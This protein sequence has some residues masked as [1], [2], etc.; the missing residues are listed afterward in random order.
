M[1]MA[2]SRP[3]QLG[4][5][6]NPSVVTPATD[7]PVDHDA[8]R[9]AD[10]L[11]VR[12][13]LDP[14]LNGRYPADVVDDLEV[15][16][17]HLPIRDGDLETISE[18]FDWLGVNYYFSSRMSGMDSAG[19]TVD[20]DGVPVE[21]DVP[22]GRPLTAMGWEIVPDGLS[23]LL[24]R[25]SRDYP[26]TPMVITESGAAFDDVPDETGF[27]Q[28]DERVAYLASHIAAVARAREA[29]A[30]VHGYFV[31]TFLDNF[32]WSY[33]YDKRF[34]LVR[35]DYDTQRRTPKHSAHWYRDTIRRVRGT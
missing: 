31:W 10:G 16:G 26:G 8:A 11:G 2:A 35:V 18:P 27:V 15:R 23:E 34:G 3:V 14:L 4:I 12:I 13:Y 22:H 24:I 6:L 28:D 9:R 20:D 17:V 29:G 25:L 30:D 19:R 7:S 1:R 33:G 32:E 21:L 5:T